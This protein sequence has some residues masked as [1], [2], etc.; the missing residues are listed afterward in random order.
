MPRYM[1]A[2]KWKSVDAEKRLIGT[3]EWRR[4]FKPELIKPDDVKIESETGKMCVFLTLSEMEAIVHFG[5]VRSIINGFDNQGRPIIYMRPGRENTE[6]SDRQ[7]RHLVWCL[8]RAKDL[9]PP[10][11]ESVAIV[12]DYKSC[13]LSTSPSI[14]IA[15]QVCGVFSPCKV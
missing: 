5:P 11:V 4:G 2:A 15:R 10:G 7:L 1:R 12:V 8:E 3:L 13:T 9:M 14:S 6:R